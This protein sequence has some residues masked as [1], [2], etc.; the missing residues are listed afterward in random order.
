MAVVKAVTGEGWTGG[1][2][3]GW[4]EGGKGWITE[5][6]EDWL[7]MLM[8]AGLVKARLVRA[9]LA[10]A[11]LVRLVKVGLVWWRHIPREISMTCWTFFAKFRSYLDKGGSTPE[12]SKFEHICSYL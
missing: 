4:I 6:G 1:A 2:G 5:A 7:V 12:T 9:R 10:R 3:E 8:E 11:R